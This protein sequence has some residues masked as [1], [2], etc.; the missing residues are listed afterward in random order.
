MKNAHYTKQ[1]R[2][3]ILWLRFL[4]IVFLFVAF[5]F[6][7]IPNTIFEYID[8]IGLVF[9][10][11][12]SQ[13][14]ST[15]GLDARGLVTQG[16]QDPS[17]QIW[18]VLSLAGLFGLAYAAFLAQKNWLRYYTL[19]PLIALTKGFSAIGMGSVAYFHPTHFFFIVGSCTDGLLFLV[20][21]TCYV[22]AIHSRTYS[23][24]SGV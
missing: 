17:Y 7:F 14:L 15:Q 16:L 20:T 24:I 10:N 9:F 19:V 18:W 12:S 11:F 13:G 8:S 3:I 22:K 23:Q 2:Q 21:L 4:T 6:A 5:A 1:E